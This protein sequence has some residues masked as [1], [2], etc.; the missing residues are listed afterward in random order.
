[1]NAPPALAIGHLRARAAM[2][3]PVVARLA[4]E[5]LV[6]EVAAA[7]PPLPPQA[8][9]MLRR[10]AL[11]L[12]GYGLDRLPDVGLRRR[13]A[14][15]ARGAIAAAAAIAGR[16]ALGAITAETAAVLFGD[17][18]ELLACLARDGL[19]GRLDVWWW[20]NLLGGGYPD[21]TRAWVD[22]PH[23]APAALRL[24]AR[25][26]LA[27][28]VVQVLDA[29]GA[30]TDGV[31]EAWRVGGGQGAPQWPAGISDS[32]S[33]RAGIPAGALTPD[34]APVSAEPPVAPPTAPPAKGTTDAA[35]EN[36][37]S[38]PPTS[39]VSAPRGLTSADVTQPDIPQFISPDLTDTR[40]SAP[41]IATQLDAYPP[42]PPD[43]LETSVETVRS[44]AVSAAAPSPGPI[45]PAA[46]SEHPVASD[47]RT[48]SVSTP[49][50]RPPSEPGYRQTRLVRPERPAVEPEPLGLPAEVARRFARF[51]R[52]AHSAAR[53]RQA[54]ATPASGRAAADAVTDS[55]VKPDHPMSL[56]QAPDTLWAGPD[57]AAPLDAAPNVVVSRYARLF[58]LVN[59]LLGDELYPDFTR[60]LDPG[61][62][63][64]IWRL[65]ALLGA[66][67][68]GPA[69]YDDAIW[70]LLERL[71]AELPVRD[72][73]WLEQLWPVP[74][75][76]AGAKQPVGSPQSRH[77]GA[78]RP[79]PRSQAR[80]PGFARWFRRYLAS[81]RAR[82]APALGVRP[83]R[84]GR[85]LAGEPARIWVSA[86]EI[87][88]VYSLEHHPVEWRLAGLDRDPGYLPSAGRGL[89]FVFE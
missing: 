66:E 35:G 41:A 56:D 72:E 54:T 84:V 79:V 64:P 53:H 85:V 81:V 32:A 28:A 89:R 71:G 58:F 80:A 77:P 27:K 39:L 44:A 59:L 1:M 83:A 9:L 22:R 29:R 25:A 86:A 63:V 68:V 14:S 73:P 74:G 15:D 78:A 24:L 47:A 21:W 82:L 65:L 50:D 33:T 11:A 45:P 8:V 55:A 60:P 13:F 3:E 46:P 48:T 37:A 62:P 5:A 18:A 57:A 10:L 4:A 16:P 38:E 31:A 52:L 76:G 69:L 40:G 88:V 75:D 70:L 20:R 42:I 87:V 23:A 49:G 7:L 30:L 67:L 36:R 34:A 19:A 43:S 61:F 51:T 17:E 2:R 6:A 26:G 12:P